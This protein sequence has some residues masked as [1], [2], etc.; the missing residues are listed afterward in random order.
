MAGTNISIHTNTHDS[1]ELSNETAVTFS[2]VTPSNR[3]LKIYI[4]D[5]VIDVFMH[6]MTPREFARFANQIEAA[7]VSMYQNAIAAEDSNENENESITEEG[8]E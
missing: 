1:R 7:G 2:G 6:G 5:T 4:N 3:L 8:T